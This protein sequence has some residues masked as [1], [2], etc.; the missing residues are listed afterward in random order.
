M[1]L[2]RHPLLVSSTLC[3]T[4]CVATACKSPFNMHC[5]QIVG[6][7]CNAGSLRASGI[8][9]IASASVSAPGISKQQSTVRGNVGILAHPPESERSTPAAGCQP[10]WMPGAWNNTFGIVESVSA[11]SLE[12]AFQQA[13]KQGMR[14][15]A[16]LVVSPTY[17]GTCSNIQGAL[18]TLVFC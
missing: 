12:A 15:S 10:M 8:Q 2:F 7:D 6:W 13:I 9:T 17:Y 18:F 5:G 14:P 4:P 16:A 1:E 11:A 3:N